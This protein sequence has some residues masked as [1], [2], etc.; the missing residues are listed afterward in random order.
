MSDLQMNI[1]ERL[2]RLGGDQGV[3]E[4][5]IGQAFRTARGSSPTAAELDR[6][7]RLFELRRLQRTG[8]GSLVKNGRSLIYR[9]NRAGY[10][11]LGPSRQVSGWIRPK[12]RGLLR[13][14]SIR[15]SATRLQ[16]AGFIREA[17]RSP[18]VAQLLRTGV[19]TGRMPAALRLLGGQMSRRAALGFAFSAAARTAG[20]LICTPTGAALLLVLAVGALTLTLVGGDAAKD[21]RVAINCDCARVDAGFLTGAFRDECRGAEAALNSALQDGTF[22]LTQ[23]NGLITGGTVCNGVAAGPAAWPFPG[24]QYAEAAPSTQQDDSCKKRSGL[25]QRCADDP[26]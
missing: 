17:R 2:V 4:R 18:A 22:E 19:A 7:A 1:L 8:G 6:L 5:Y 26:N 14:L 20:A 15:G 11:G 12:T 10:G 21:N 25:I 9:L 24:A 3:W 23:E 13:A 16:L